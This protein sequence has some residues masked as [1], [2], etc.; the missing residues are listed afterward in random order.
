M[1]E[2]RVRKICRGTLRVSWWLGAFVVEVVV[3]WTMAIIV[4]VGVVL[5][6]LA[7]GTHFVGGP[8]E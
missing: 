4:L 2:Q 5:G 8:P 6:A 3:I 7:V 1:P